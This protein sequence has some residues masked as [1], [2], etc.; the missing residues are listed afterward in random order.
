MSFE[1]NIVYAK[2]LCGDI[3][4]LDCCPTE[5]SIWYTLNEYYPNEFPLNKTDIQYFINDN[6][7]DT[8]NVKYMFMV[9]VLPSSSIE[10]I[11][12]TYVPKTQTFTIILLSGSYEFS[13]TDKLPES[14]LLNSHINILPKTLE[15]VY[16]INENGNEN[17]CL[18]H[19]F[20]NYISPCSSK[21]YNTLDECIENCSHE[22]SR[23]DENIY[24][25]CHLT[26]QAK[27]DIKRIIRLCK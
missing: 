14:N 26:T 24:Q 21:S 27:I 19:K 12:S 18:K 5:K 15:I 16:T 10:F 9:Y 4:A 7:I 13:H 20:G 8:D 2:T 11:G 1:K 3:L 17:V 6:I 23:I 25:Y 22:Y